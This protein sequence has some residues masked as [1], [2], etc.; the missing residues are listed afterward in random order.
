MAG[1]HA[2]GCTCTVT[3]CARG[4]ARMP[5]HQVLSLYLDCLQVA[6]TKAP[7]TLQADIRRI[8]GQEFGENKTLAKSDIE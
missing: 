2:S 8:A 4:S 6:R 1:A 3:L 5:A 7:A